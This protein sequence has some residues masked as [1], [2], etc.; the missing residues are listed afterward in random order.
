[1][2][3]VLWSFRPLSVVSVVGEDCDF[4]IVVSHYKFS[5]FMGIPSYAKT[6]CFK[7]DNDL[8][9]FFS[10]F[11]GDVVVKFLEV[12]TEIHNP[13]LSAM[14]IVVPV[15]NNGGVIQSF[16]AINVESSLYLLDDYFWILIILVTFRIIVIF[17]LMQLGPFSKI[18]AVFVRV[19]TR[20]LNCEHF[21]GILVHLFEGCNRCIKRTV[22]CN[23]IYRH[24]WPFNI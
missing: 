3:V 16:N 15:G 23:K 20:A 7:G 24:R 9:C 12:S 6:S 17:G 19:V 2:I 18:Y 10:S 4:S 5:N 1:M 8:L 22:L 14:T 11:R 13:D 21:I